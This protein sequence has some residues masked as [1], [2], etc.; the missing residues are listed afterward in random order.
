[1]T[2]FVA[3][4]VS[5]I[6]VIGGDSQSEFPIYEDFY[7]FEAGSKDELDS[8]IKDA[9]RVI[10]SAGECEF[11]GKPA[12]QKCIGVRKIRSVYNPPPLDIDQDRPSDFTELTHS[13]LMAKSFQ[14]VESYAKG[15]AV[16]LLCVDDA[17]NADDQS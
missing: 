4:I 2:W 1:M 3:S 13:F 6:E 9:M 14:E 12:R 8:K 15:E 11:D 7:L 17:D 16:Y 10:D 5:C